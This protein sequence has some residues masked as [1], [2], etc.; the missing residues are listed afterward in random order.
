MTLVIITIKTL[1]DNM[2]KILSGGNNIRNCEKVE[3]RS[4]GSQKRI[5]EHWQDKNK[6]KVTSRVSQK[7]KC[8]INKWIDQQENIW[9]REY[10]RREKMQNIKNITQIYPE[11]FTNINWVI[12]LLLWKQVIYKITSDQKYIKQVIYSKSKWNI[13]KPCQKPPRQII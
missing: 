5:L 9:C 13:S 11:S 4:E 12:S 2:E 3:Q 8:L 10:K 1:K 6:K 7:N